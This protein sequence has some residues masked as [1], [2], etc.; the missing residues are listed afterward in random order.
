MPS[1]VAAY[2][3]TIHTHISG[4]DE[5]AASQAMPSLFEKTLCKEEERP[6]ET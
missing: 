1:A 3:F 2:S 6:T 4:Q 5:C